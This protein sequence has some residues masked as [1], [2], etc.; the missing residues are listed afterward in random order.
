MSPVFVAVKGL[1]GGSGKPGR[2]V[3][4]SGESDYE[5]GGDD[6]KRRKSHRRTMPEDK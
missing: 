6:G 1:S 4:P 2:S 3:L 5:D